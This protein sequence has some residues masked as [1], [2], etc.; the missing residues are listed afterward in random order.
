MLIINGI[1]VLA[2]VF[3]MNFRLQKKVYKV[4]GVQTIYPY[5][6]GRTMVLDDSTNDRTFTIDAT[7][8]AASKIGSQFTFGNIGTGRLTL[9]MPTG[10]KVSDSSAAGTIY[11]DTNSIAAITIELVTATQFLVISATGTWTTT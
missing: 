7:V 10:V 4:T 5:H 9:Q 6:S 1:Q 2:N 11:S 3:L 8:C